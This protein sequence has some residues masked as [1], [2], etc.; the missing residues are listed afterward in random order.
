MLGFALLLLE[1]IDLWVEFNLFG[2]PFKG[3]W[4]L[5]PFPSDLAGVTWRDGGLEPGANDTALLRAN[6]GALDPR[7]EPTNEGFNEGLRDPVPSIATPS[8]SRAT[9]SMPISLGSISSSLVSF[10]FPS[11]SVIFST[12]SFPSTVSSSPSSK[13]ALLSCKYFSNEFTIAVPTRISL[14]NIL[15]SRTDIVNGGQYLSS[16]GRSC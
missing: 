10:S 4:T 9:L 3:V 1:A 8:P 14:P 16:S 5:L 2:V 6:D 12:L 7:L 15:V 13:Y 11:W